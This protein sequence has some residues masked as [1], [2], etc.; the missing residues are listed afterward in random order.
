MNYLV[1]YEVLFIQTVNRGQVAAFLVAP[2]FRFLPAL[3]LGVRDGC[4][5]VEA[6]ITI[7]E[8]VCFGWAYWN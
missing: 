7:Q 4:T 1:V 6:R 2:S 5:E 8:P 3:T